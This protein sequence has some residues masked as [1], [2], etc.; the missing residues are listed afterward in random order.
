MTSYLQE[1]HREVWEWFNS[2]ESKSNY[3]DE[4][5][6]HLLKTTY[7]MERENHTELY[8]LTDEVLQALCITVPVTLYKSHG[9]TFSSAALFF[10]P[11][12][13]HVVLVGGVMELLNDEE[14][15]SLLAHELSHF[16]LWTEESGAYLVTDQVLNTMR[17]EPRAENNHV[18]SARFF[19]LYTE[20]FADRG[21]L[22]VTNEKAMISTLI[23]VHTGMK[24]VNPESYLQQAEEIFSKD[25]S[26][27]EGR[28]HP[29]LYIRVK[30]IRANSECSDEEEYE[31]VLQSLIEGKRTLENYDLLAQQAATE[32]TKEFLNYHLRH[33]WLQTETVMAHLKHFFLDFEF[34][35]IE[36]ISL[37]LEKEAQPTKSYYAYLLLDFASVDPELEENAIAASFQ[38]AEE[39]GIADDLENLIRKELRLLKKDAVRIRKN[40][41]KM[42]QQASGE[43]AINN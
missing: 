18:Q 10:T 41:G 3:S 15:K 5:E 26:S 24:E 6:L 1:E 29:E 17:N 32:E 21:G 8:A 4:V 42:V 34:S 43:A 19:Q 12:H 40:A 14:M 27:S 39:I 30:A 13:G 25:K 2:A 11:G 9:T 37:N 20:I 23:K 16:K 33:P 31:T 35:D 38:T 36:D 22:I 7:R 28:T